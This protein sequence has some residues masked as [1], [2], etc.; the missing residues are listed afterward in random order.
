[1]LD[2]YVFDIPTQAHASLKTDLQA[3][4]AQVPVSGCETAF[5]TP[6]SFHQ[7]MIDL[8]RRQHDGNLFYN[9]P[10]FFQQ[11]L[12]YLPFRFNCTYSKGHL[13]VFVAG[14]SHH[15]ASYGYLPG[16]G[17]GYRSLIGQEVTFV[18][19][20]PAE[21]EFK[22]FA[23]TQV[24]LTKDLGTRLHLAVTGDH[25]NLWACS[26]STRPL[27]G[28][29]M[30]TKPTTTLKFQ[31]P[32]TAA[33]TSTELTWTVYYQGDEYSDPD[34]TVGELPVKPYPDC[35]D[36][37]KAAGVSRTGREY[38]DD[39]EDAA[40][41]GRY[42]VKLLTKGAF[43]NT[44]VWRPGPGGS[45]QILDTFDS[46]AAWAHKAPDGSTTGILRL[47]SFKGEKFPLNQ[48]LGRLASLNPAR[49][50]VDLRGNGGGHIC[51]ALELAYLLSN[52]FAKPPTAYV[53]V[54]KSPMMESMARNQS[55]FYDGHPEYQFRPDN[56]LR[57]EVSGAEHDSSAWYLGQTVNRNGAA[58]SQ[59]VAMNCEGFTSVLDFKLDAGYG[60]HYRV[61]T[62]KLVSY[63]R[64]RLM[65]LVD[66]HCGGT[67]ATFARLMKTSGAAVTTK[68]G[69]GELGSFPGGMLADTDGLAC[70]FK[71]MQSK[72]SQ[73]GSAS[74]P[75]QDFMLQGEGLSLPIAELYSW[76]GGYPT[77][78]P[79]ELTQ[80]VMADHTVPYSREMYDI[81]ERDALTAVYS[82]VIRNFGAGT[83]TPLAPAGTV[84]NEEGSSSGTVVGYFF[85][86]IFLGPLLV[87]LC[88]VAVTKLQ[89]GGVDGLCGFCRE[90]CGDAWSSVSSH[91]GY[92]QLGSGDG[93]GGTTSAHAPGSFGAQAESICNS[94]GNWRAWMP[95]MG[96]SSLQQQYQDLHE[97]PP[98]SHDNQVHFPLQGLELEGGEEEEDHLSTDP[99]RRDVSEASPLGH[100]SASLLERPP[101]G[102]WGNPNSVAVPEQ[103]ASGLDHDLEGYSEAASLDQDGKGAL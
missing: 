72:V 12:M 61:K 86:G 59:R 71:A 38:S 27:W 14:L 58:F 98:I 47:L 89:E 76:A 1:V 41:S 90:V 29:A 101:A 17:A 36:V 56:F 8:V 70:Q 57:D 96:G 97:G 22:S 88:F 52:Q 11:S 103:A 62:H 92:G 68:L 40:E 64:E 9:P 99:P 42:S 80:P 75:F 30:P 87:A 49:L 73:A 74:Y 82:S 13:R 7:R 60:D 39:D 5:P 6:Y 32:T 19:G 35:T 53:D 28:C 33:V 18:D 24:G 102:D 46:A 15:A 25:P 3:V 66:A 55:Q 21:T 26:F 51:H 83:G 93:A 95:G 77:D 84:L 31:H 43:L 85:L 34:A 78:T 2:L 48:V 69:M 100:S 4:L 79:L 23:E 45:L 67:C 91:A 94:I 81:D 63:P 10:A 65:V 20:V 50:V 37:Q 44:D 16:P 54:K